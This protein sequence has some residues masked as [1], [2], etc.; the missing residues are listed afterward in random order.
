MRIR[1]WSWRLLIAVLA[2][3]HMSLVVHADIP[4]K[5]KKKEQGAKALPAYKACAA[6][7]GDSGQGKLGIAPSLD[8]KSFWSVVSDKQFEEM[9]R[10]LHVQTS[11]AAGAAKLPTKKIARIASTLRSAPLSEPLALNNAATTGNR[12]SGKDKY[13][14]ICAMCHGAAALG[15]REGANAPAIKS[16]EFLSIVPDGY[17][18]HMLKH[19][20]EETMMRSFTPGSVTSWAALTDAEIEDIIAFLRDSGP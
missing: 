4:Q 9:V 15:Y 20:K 1:K 8:T 10:K 16:T 19:G 2:L 14:K 3:C 12:D 18:R 13:D 11:F 7:H 6:C 17:L 5:T